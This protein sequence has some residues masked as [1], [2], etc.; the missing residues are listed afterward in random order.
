MQSGASVNDYGAR[1]ARDLIVTK[2]QGFRKEKN[3]KKRGVSGPL[4][5]TGEAEVQ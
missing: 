3:K 4:R 2:G 1:A 5:V